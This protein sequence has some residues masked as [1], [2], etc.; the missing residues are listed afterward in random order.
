M[1]AWMAAPIIVSFFVTLFGLVLFFTDLSQYHYCRKYSDAR[2]SY[3]D[4]VKSWEAHPENWSVVDEEYGKVIRENVERKDRYDNSIRAIISPFWDLIKFRCWNRRR[5]KKKKK[6]KLLDGT[7][8]LNCELYKEQMRDIE[9]QYTTWIAG[10]PEYAVLTEPVDSRPVRIISDK[11]LTS[12][13][14]DAKLMCSVS[15]GSQICILDTVDGDYRCISTDE[16]VNYIP[17]SRDEVFLHSVS[18][19]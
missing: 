5:K 1:S 12:T 2:I 3:K 4:F 19:K 14:L 16:G 7:N 11:D 15:S 9:N 8:R 18:S 13:L 17:L 6:E 10:H